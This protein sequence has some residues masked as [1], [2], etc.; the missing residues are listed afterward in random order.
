MHIQID[1]RRELDALSVW[2]DRQVERREHLMCAVV[3]CLTGKC[4]I[5]SHSAPSAQEKGG[6]SCIALL[7]YCAHLA[8]NMRDA[9][10]HLLQLERTV[11]R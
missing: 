2:G 7:T 5:A 8:S 10:N 6:R 9:M 1:C 11:L 3:L 4:M